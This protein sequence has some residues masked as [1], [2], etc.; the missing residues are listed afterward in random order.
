MIARLLTCMRV[1]SRL[2]FV[3]LCGF[4]P[5]L[6][7]ARDFELGG[8][9]LAL[10]E[11]TDSV[12]VY[13][14]SMRLNRAL[15]EWNVEVMVSNKSARAISGP[16]MLVVEGFQ[17][18]SGPR[19]ADGNSEAKAFYDLTGHLNGGTLLQTRRTTSK[20]ISLGYT[21]GGAPRVQARVFAGVLT[22]TA[23]MGFV[24]AL[25][26][27]GQPLGKVA[28]EQV[29]VL[30]TLA[31]TTD[32][33]FG[34]ATVIASTATSTWKFSAPGRLSV[35]RRAEL[36]TNEVTVIPYPRLPLISSEEFVLSPLSGGEISNG[37]FEA[38]FQPGA[39]LQGTTGR[40]TQLSGQTLPLFLPAGW[41][42]LQAF[43]L[44]LT[45]APT[46]P[47]IA[48]VRLWEPV[49]ASD[50]AVWIR[51][52]EG[53]LEWNVMATA[54]PGD[55]LNVQLPGGGIFALVVA[56]SGSSAPPIATTGVALP[57]GPLI[58]PDASNLAAG[59]IVTPPTSPASTNVHLVTADAVVIVTNAT[60]PLVSGTILRGEVSEEYTLQNGS[61]RFPPG[62]E[63]FVVA[64]QR[65][66][67]GRAETVHA[68]FPL[69]PL[70]LFPPEELNEGVVRMDL[71]A[72]GSFSGGVLGTNGGV[73]ANGTVRVV[74]R[75]ESLAR[76]EAVQLRSLVATNFSILA[77]TNMTVV[78]AFELA[79]GEVGNGTRLGLHLNSAPTN[80]QFVLARVI[81]GEGTYGLEPRERLRT[82]GNGQLFTEE[83]VSG[84]R[85]PGLNVAGQYLLVQ[86]A[87]Q[88]GIVSGVVR[89]GANQP[90]E[91]LP[92]RVRG[93]PWLTFSKIDGGYRLL[94][95]VGDS[96]VEV[97]DTRTG[98]FGT[99]L[100]TVPV[101]LAPISSSVAAQS[102][103]P[104]VASLTPANGSS[105]V[106]RVT[107]VVVEF[108]KALN[109][110]TFVSNGMRLIGTN[111]QAVAGS[112][113][114]NLANTK[115][116]L[117]PNAPL[118]PA[119]RYTVVLSSAITDTSGRLLE[120]TNQFSFTTAAL[121]VRDPAAQLIIY[122]PGATNVPAAILSQIP[123]YTPG[124]NQNAI[125]VRGTPGVADPE[126]A[127]VLA[128]EST[129]ETSTVLSKP[130]GSFVSVIEGQEE[131]FV[132]ATF[133]NLNG[134]R[135]YVPVS[136]Q[137]FDNGFVGLYRQGGILEA[138]SDGGPVQVFIEPEA[139]QT[140]TKLR[141]KTMTIAQLNQ[142]LGGTQPEAAKIAAGAITL[143]G[144]GTPM[145]GPV[146]VKFNVNLLTAGYP[147][148]ANPREAAVAL[149]RVT[150]D[151]NVKAFQ[152]LDQLV[153]VP[154]DAPPPRNS[155]TNIAGR[156]TAQASG[157]EIFY[158]TLQ[159]VIGLVPG[160]GAANGIFK[161]ILVP[162]L[163]GGKPIV[164]KGLTLQSYEVTKAQSPFAIEDPLLSGFSYSMLGRA[165]AAID[166][167]NNAVSTA[168][169]LNEQLTDG[170]LG[171]PL[172][173][174]FVS[175]QNFQTPA[176]PGRLRP[177]MI[178]AT[179]DR[180]GKYLMVA[181][182]TPALK[183]TP[184]DIYLLI[185]T[186]PKFSD[187]ES[188]GLF[189]LT[190]ISL[191]G[192]AFKNFVFRDPLPFSTAPQV[193]VAHSPPYPAAGQAVQLQVNA[194]QGFV[195]KP[196]INVFK[197]SVFPTNRNIEEVIIS[198]ITNVELSANR[199]RWMGTV[200]AT[201][202]IR[203]VVLRV[204]VISSSGVVHPA[205]RYRISFNGEPPRT[206]DPI[207]PSDPDDKKGPYVVSSLP[208]ERGYM[209]ESGKIRIAFSE[210]INRSV[211][212]NAS[213]IT[214]TGSGEPPLP[215][216]QLSADQTELT[217]EF[218][219]L[220][221]DS[222]YA[223]TLSGDSIQDLNGNPLDQRPS[224]TEPDSF[225]VNFRTTPA[226]QF[227]LPGVV[228]GRGSAIQGSRLYVLDAAQQNL[229]RT[230]DI[231][232]PSDPQ[233]LSS[234]RVVGQP[235]DLV[236]IP[237]FGYRLRLH[238]DR[239]TNDLV[240][241]VG[242]DLNVIVD[243]LDSVI[244]PGQYIR[245]FDMADPRNPVEIAAP[246]VTYR[247]GSALTKIRWHPPHLVYQEFA[248]DLHQIA[249]VNLQELL[250]GYNSPR[251]DIDIFPVNG[252]EGL[253]FNGDGDYVDEGIDANND[254]DF[255]DPGDTRAD[256]M[257]IPQR[258]PA[259]FA[260]KK[261][262][263]VIEGTTQKVLDFS[264]SGG[265]LGVTLSRG[266]VLTPGG[267]PTRDA[268][269]PQYRTLSF[270]DFEVNPATASVNFA[271][272]DYPGRVTIIDGLPIVVTNQLRTMVVALVSISPDRQGRQ[273]IEIIDIS[274][275]ENPRFVNL[276][277]LPNEAVAG[278][279]LSLKLRADGFLEAVTSSHVL[280]LD[281]LRLAAPNPP[282]DQ[283]HPAIVGFIPQAGART[284][285]TGDSPPG[286]RSVADGGRAHLVQT[287]PPMS[288]VS[289]PDS[290][291]V[292][293]PRRL[294]RKREDLES[295][296]AK[297]TT[298][299]QL[300]PAR[301]KPGPSQVSQLFPADPAVHYHVLVDAPG[302]SGEKINLGLESLSFAGW[303]MPNKGMGFPPVRAVS[304]QALEALDIRLRE[305]CDAP[306]REL[307]AYR[308]SDDPTSPFFNQYLSRPFV[309]VYES[310]SIA[311]L[312]LQRL[313]ADR[314]I[315]WSGAALRAFLDP[316]EIG[317]NAIKPFAAR[318]D[319][320][321][322]LISPIA[323]ITV[324]TLDV[325]YA[326]GDNPP[327]VAGSDAL[328]GTAGSVMPQNG[329][330]RFDD[331]D[332][333]LPSPR[334][335]ITIERTIA[336]QDT[337]DGP[338]GL[339]WDFNYNQRLTELQPHLF[340]EGIK[341]PL[342]ERATTD[343]SAVANSKDMLFHSGE[344][345]IIHFRWVASTIPPEYSQDPLVTEFNYREIVS[346]YFLPEPGLFDLLVKFKDGKYERLTPGGMRFRYNAVGRL[347]AIIDTFPKNRHELEYDRNGWLV[348]IDDRSVTAD[349]FVEFGYYRRRGDPNFNAGLDEVT[350]NTFVEGKIC[351][352]R[353]FADGDVLYFYNDE[354]L[355]IRR[356]GLVTAG[357][358]GGFSGRAKTFYNYKDCK[359]V[360]VSANESGA[361]IFNADMGSTSPE[362]QVAKA[363][364]GVT[365]PVTVTVPPNNKASTIG[366][367]KSSV[368][369]ADGRTVEQTFDPRGYVASTRVSGA[370]GEPAELRQERNEHGQVTVLRYPEGRVETLTYDPENPN[371]RS[372]GN[373][374]RRQVD[375]GP[376]GGTGFTETYNHDPRYNL[377][378]G[379]QVDANG[380][381]T[382]I[383]L[384]ADG[385]DV[386]SAQH[387]TTG[388]DQM[389]YNDNG[390]L[391]T[392]TDLTGRET[393]IGYQSGTGYIQS[394]RKG[395]NTHTY[396]YGGDYASKLGKPSSV[397]PPEG[398]ATQTRY[399]V[400]L[401]TVEIRRGPLA[402]L[403]AYDEQ[404]RSTYQRRELGD[405][406]IL[407]SRLA[408]NA[409]GFVTNSIT[410]GVEVNGTEKTIGYTFVPDDHGRLKSI[411]HPGG[412]SET[413]DYDN[414]GNRIRRTIGNYVEEGKFDLHGNMT[415][416]R[417]GGAVVMTAEYDGLDRPLRVSNKTGVGDDE[418]ETSTYYPGGEVRS[419]AKSDSFGV[420]FQQ[421]IDSI[422]AL[423]RPLQTT[424][425]GSVISPSQQFTYEPRR[426]TVRGSRLT[427]VTTWDS[428]GYET[429]VSD[430]V[431]STV[432]TA[433]GNGRARRIERHEDG[434]TYADIFEYDAL[435]NRTSIA[436]LAGV[437]FGYRTRADGQFLSITNGRNSVVQM[438]HSAL[439]EVLSEKRADGMEFRFRHDE[440]RQVVYSGDPGAG[441]TMGFDDQFRLTSQQQRNGASLVYQNFDARNMPQSVTLPGGT[442]TLQ[443]DLQRRPVHKTVNYQGTTYESTMQYD[444]MNRVR[445]ETYRQ[446]ATGENRAVYNFDA[447]GVLTSEQ[448]QED[449]ADYTVAYEYNTDGTRKGTI[450]PSGARVTE[451]RDVTGRL[452]QVLDANGNIIHAQG[453]K[454][455][456][457]ASDVVL[458]NSIQVINQFDA[459]GR[460]TASR[461]TRAGSNPPMAH[462]RYSYNGA[463]GIDLRQDLHRGGRADQFG[464]DNSDRL[465]RAVIGGFP[466]NTSTVDGAIYGR[467][468]NYNS[469][470]LDF[471]VSATLQGDASGAGMFSSEWAAHDPFLVPG[472][473]DNVDWNSDLMGNVNRA[474]LHF[475]S[476]NGT[477]STPVDATLVHNG[478][479]SLV[480]IERA[481]G[482]VIENRFRPDGLRYARLVTEGGLTRHRHFVYDTEG[483][484]IEE[485]E[486]S[487][488]EAGLMARYYYASSDAPVAADLRNTIAEGFQRYYFARDVSGSV[489][490]VMDRTGI[491]VER[492]IYDPFGQP[493][494]EG[495][496]TNPPRVQRVL[497]GGSGT[498]LIELSEPVGPVTEDP[499]AGI[500]PLPISLVVS[501]LVSGIDAESELMTNYPGFRPYTVVRV[502]PRATVSGT[503]TMTFNGERIADEW[504]LAG[505]TESLELTVTGAAGAVYYARTPATSTAA[506]RHA[507][508]TVGS[509]F[510][511]H[512]QYFDYDTGLIYLRA[513]F[514]DPAS[515]MF[516]EPDPLG[517]E[518]SVNLYAAFANNP[519]SM[520]DP[521]GLKAGLTRKVEIRQQRKARERAGDD[522]YDFM[523][524][525]GLTDLEIRA[526]ANVL[527]RRAQEQGQDI[528]LSVRKFQKYDKET[529]AKVDVATAQARRR[530]AT[531]GM[532]LKGAGFKAKNNIFA[533]GRAIFK[534]FGNMI[535]GKRTQRT[536]ITSDVDA[537]HVMINGQ[538]ATVK[539]IRSL[540]GEIN[541]EFRRMHKARFAHMGDKAPAANAPFQHEAH[542]HLLHQLGQK[543]G[544]KVGKSGYVSY[545]DLQGIGHPQDAFQ[546]SFS[547]GANGLSTR[548]LKRE[549]VAQILSDARDDFNFRKQ[550][551]EA[552]ME[553]LDAVGLLEVD[554]W[555]SSFYSFG[556]GS[557]PTPGMKPPTSGM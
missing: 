419:V 359:I 105:N 178:Y 78:A 446:G 248:A 283:A 233:L 247:V 384:R 66:G 115:A 97:R 529:G 89:N 154:A 224:T 137:E 370:T 374:K 162:L 144:E 433:D 497:G 482:V 35:W 366:N 108:T 469:A 426:L 463:D 332:L 293:D 352:M 348:R 4:L 36:R 249:F 305:M 277:H 43:A 467:D 299:P 230:F 500:N 494:I 193:N 443:Y 134:S 313:E 23:P 24:R 430:P 87:P 516:L 11:V 98:D 501:N 13:Y 431:M 45:T 452:L 25:N 9:R 49:T 111:G 538:F 524:A 343:I 19:R 523:S 336:G 109:P 84:E 254:G 298:V 389:S 421:T 344:G 268:V 63:N 492:V 236:V 190:D 498:I 387:D 289:F 258:R 381:T 146:K 206:D 52:D 166:A 503:V 228:N 314:E 477:S 197:E 220:A 239:R 321:R 373:L 518:D 77:G 54:T 128:N 227:N 15:N 284:R 34:S 495:R 176:T 207:P 57:G 304:S 10:E 547:K 123:A 221:P 173:G 310:M 107:S 48:N 499:G 33:D 474:R 138:Q 375:P 198:G 81:G 194:S 363:G 72:P 216:V 201:N 307:A 167:F 51:F 485:Y 208:V 41:S 186:H 404:G 551:D 342:V 417:Q 226:V 130:D 415:E 240:A 422:D 338:F 287:P 126:V 152:V 354:G 527:R 507:R 438:E 204:S 552:L 478:L 145:D 75:P 526:I 133:I 273:S 311:D 120:G 5:L 265:T 394:V 215:A 425:N 155:G 136:R 361:P 185:A 61:K 406:K 232:N 290:P 360:G 522:A 285:S 395:N 90:A 119:T 475:R 429:G 255:E 82:D 286:V 65:P 242:G 132:S 67:D 388:A 288:F 263:R 496:D 357:E 143:E 448:Y 203:G 382:T 281:P 512:G 177:G 331:T 365:G 345:R 300:I 335:P 101:N 30:G 480:R 266:V 424:L 280:L 218:A 106:P 262:S 346:D 534:K 37:W 164:V 214:L 139:I 93:Q 377:A 170:L 451:S 69:R 380:F 544:K 256:T 159:S 396:G 553:Q 541:R 16:M 74:A 326:M 379:T 356:E 156:L 489:V 362:K 182:T 189:A 245:V 22:P 557:A 403:R 441:F 80:G 490:V 196:L 38:Q 383:R 350:P 515:G 160:Y 100:V 179:S 414:R 312:N 116:T 549:E 163:I 237:N 328:P 339:G 435:D 471:L 71:F 238:S 447:S 46:G 261:A 110:G 104:R 412:T 393:T 50:R 269:P 209:D 292:V 257:P 118:E 372:R 161:Y 40:V 420:S 423:G 140:K 317:N 439:G 55:R 99:Q 556:D 235:R 76:P 334:L 533:L 405:G 231:S 367:Q 484:L 31:Q 252:K 282:T 274:Q 20:T 369:Q 410:E 272:G 378:S 535:G 351:R 181:P 303:P 188:Q 148:N 330:M 459:R 542:A 460:M 27:V 278:N 141:L 327:P 510:L 536:A 259:E 127:V 26:E 543:V 442:M 260:G 44:D 316:T 466:T 540:F 180:D 29:G 184:E 171:R 86:L 53:N 223:L 85:L 347:E 202:A 88:Q 399:N 234:V 376:R 473:V 58:A 175:L 199:M 217:I 537:L 251:A 250:I 400:N 210:P 47:L 464:Y 483:R 271:D 131:D 168:N 158:G 21:A 94:A 309:V 437:R 6:C 297:S 386:E 324:P 513:R 79:M 514:Y 493:V 95:P 554:D 12:D 264:V 306:I 509:S 91:G 149:A 270:N 147:T 428:A 488:P 505:T 358:N 455:Y 539:E 368:T 241:V 122:A 397:S 117:L 487:Q 391:E 520:R 390:Q 454:G 411:I 450:Y 279:L 102:A 244:V 532:L 449:G 392:S 457:Q 517:Y 151:Q 472:Q 418:I 174:A 276:L 39:V 315:L 364:S 320:E 468:Y 60:G 531:S 462:L 125:V 519:V 113:S 301:V 371:Y 295:L 530:N 56:D 129:G 481:D 2:L 8:A 121:S 103:G 329:E 407:I 508:S 183:L 398:E 445:R 7:A 135:V 432:I 548:D 124:T 550:N 205:L 187:K 470:G 62:F 14:S 267:Q 349:R 545:N 28:I 436:D 211:E 302:G 291:F 402:E 502:R 191:A 73:A 355:L 219:G 114:L 453:W 456:N 229:L 465:V 308:M 243:D 486:R 458:G 213:G 212:Q 444:A 319:S 555:P 192:V 169:T 153:F 32:A 511:F 401:Q 333:S 409:N 340:P 246:I 476:R 3:G 195:G 337:Y 461:F 440:E 294:P 142:E 479:G 112:V 200:Q 322:K 546:I 341:M 64:Y 275:P 528:T 68:R 506:P 150:D 70:L 296:L 504:G 225:T 83:P 325:G 165:G 323:S 427:T 17:G 96:T 385:R 521:S 1:P 222:E 408:Y 416:M 434:A 18:T 92:V 253:D 42:P 59:G 353:D 413:I 157:E 172:A 318:V 525:N 491:P